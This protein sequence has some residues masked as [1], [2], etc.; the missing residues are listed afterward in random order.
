MAL[1]LAHQLSQESF[2]FLPLQ[3]AM[4][5]VAVGPPLEELFLL[6]PKTTKTTI[7][8]TNSTCF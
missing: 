8:Q 4:Q 3:H 5:L 1:F 2:L 6:Q 7:H